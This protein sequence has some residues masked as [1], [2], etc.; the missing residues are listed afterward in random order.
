VEKVV[1]EAGEVCVEDAEDDSDI[2]PRKRISRAA[3]R[4]KLRTT[5][6]PHLADIACGLSRCR[7]KRGNFKFL[8]ICDALLVL[9]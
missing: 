5:P 2:Q 6:Y 7:L 8:F 9:T 4:Q 1:E 3:V